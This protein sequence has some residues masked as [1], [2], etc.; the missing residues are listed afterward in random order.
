MCDTEVEYLGAESPKAVGLEP[1]VIGLEVAVDDAVLVRLLH[2]GANLLKDLH[3]A[4]QRQALLFAEHLAQAAPVEVFHDQVGHF[5]I[6]Q[7]CESEVGDVD[8]MRMAQPARRTSLAPEAFDEVGIPHELRG[9]QLQG[10][11]PPGPDVGRQIHGT[12][13]TA[14]E[15]AFEAVFVGKGRT[16]A[17]QR[18]GNMGV[19]GV[20][21]GHHP[22]RVPLGIGVFHGRVSDCVSDRVYL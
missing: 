6:T 9:D 3:H 12:H 11:I 13:P 20:I 10:D 21:Q 2:R 14:P 4:R 17:I 5:V 8:D 15:E 19:I 7:P 22:N 1:D 18:A 16:Y